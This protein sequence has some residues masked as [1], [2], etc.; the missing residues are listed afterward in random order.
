MSPQV[1]AALIIAGAII[2]ATALWIYFSPFQTCVRVRDAQY[3][4]L[5]TDGAI[6]N[7]LSCTGAI[8]GGR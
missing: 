6:V 5:D 1:K 7:R 8:G 2:I 3:D 4:D